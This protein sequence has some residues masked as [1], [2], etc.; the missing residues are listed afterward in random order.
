MA[1]IRFLNM[2]LFRFWWGQFKLQ[3]PEVVQ[4][5]QELMLRFTT[6]FHQNLPN[7]GLPKP[8]MQYF[9]GRKSL[10]PKVLNDTNLEAFS[11]LA[12]GNSSMSDNSSGM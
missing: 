7:Y 10:S 6:V 8:M 5:E 3:N 4:T 1:K 9:L 2:F 11:Q 12:I